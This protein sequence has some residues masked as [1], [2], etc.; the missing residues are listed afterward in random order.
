MHTLAAHRANYGNDEFMAFFQ[1]NYIHGFQ[2]LT[3]SQRLFVLHWLDI[4]LKRHSKQGPK[5]PWRDPYM[6]AHYSFASACLSIWKKGTN[7]RP[8]FPTRK[9]Y[10]RVLGDI[11]THGTSFP[12]KS[13]IASVLEDMHRLGR[14]YRI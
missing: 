11:Y 9:S 6:K 2:S 14:E 7:R 1:F 12:T 13:D 10:E 8:R 4:V 5:Y 3:D